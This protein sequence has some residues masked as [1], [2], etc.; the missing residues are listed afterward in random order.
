MNEQEIVSR[1][2]AQVMSSMSFRDRTFELFNKTNDLD[3][4]S[5]SFSMFSGPPEQISSGGGEG[6]TI[7]AAW[8]AK[9]TGDLEITLI[10]GDIELGPDTTIA[11]ASITNASTTVTPSTG[12]T[13]WVVWVE[14]DLSD[15]SAEMFNAASVEELT[16]EEKKTICQ[17]VIC[18]ATITDD[19]IDEVK[20]CQVGNIFI[21]RL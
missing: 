15:E 10:E 8:Y 5:F 11:W 19:V 18:K 17:K 3:N 21:P 16:S 2:L 12:Q 7:N 13:E 1:V 4:D 6:D 14:V 9:K 20:A